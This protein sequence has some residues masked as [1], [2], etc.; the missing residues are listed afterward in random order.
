MVHLQR[1]PSRR[2]SAAEQRLQIPTLELG[3]FR[4]YLNHA[5]FTFGEP[6]HIL[7]RVD[8][9]VFS[10]SAAAYENA[11]ALSHLM[12]DLAAFAA[13]FRRR[14]R[15][16]EHDDVFVM[17]KPCLDG[18]HAGMLNGL[19]MAVLVPCLKH[20]VLDDALV[21]LG[22]TM[23]QF[24]R[25]VLLAIVHFR[26]F[27]GDEKTKMPLVLR[28]GVLVDAVGFSAQPL[29]PVAFLHGNIYLIPFARG[30]GC[31]ATEI[32]AYP[33]SV[34]L[35]YELGFWIVDGDLEEIPQW[36]SDEFGKRQFE[37]VDP[38][39]LRKASNAHAAM[40]ALDSDSLPIKIDGIIDAWLPQGYLIDLGKESELAY[41]GAA[42][43][44]RCER[45]E[46]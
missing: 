22:E 25:D 1:L 31:R 19:A 41:F 5:D 45:F 30:E 44:R 14:A 3:A 36:G 18:S 17:T 39:K 43:F 26:I 10:D 28:P 6:K 29:E 11:V 2:K 20:L 13:E 8:V 21:V 42:P 34:G 46:A 9:A 32:Y 4:T 7:R 12:M 33:L 24:A 40:D 35:V 16:I 23:R 15:P 37:T 38:P 27:A